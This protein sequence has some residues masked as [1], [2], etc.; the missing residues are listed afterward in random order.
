MI[1]AATKGEGLYP[2]VLAQDATVPGQ[3]NPLF[4]PSDCQEPSLFNKVVVSGKVLICTYGF[5]YVFG[6]STLQQLVKTV[7]A[8]G[9]SGVVL[10]VDSDGSGSKFD[11]VP[12]RIPAI[13]LLTTGDSSVSLEITSS[14]SLPGRRMFSIE[15]TRIS[16][17]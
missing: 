8:V 14:L 6:G 17:A 1:T 7:E 11:P 9:A 10:V 2:L 16:T 13:A 4:S 15:I 12:L 5:S 3:S